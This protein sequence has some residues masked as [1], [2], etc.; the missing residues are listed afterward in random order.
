MQVTITKINRTTTDKKG[1]ALKTK[2]GRPYTRISLKTDQHEDKW[3]SGFENADTKSWKQGDSVEIEVTQ[4]GEYLN[5]KTPK[6]G[7]INDQA[8]K[9]IFD[10]TETILNKM[11]GMSFDIESLKNHLMPKKAKPVNDYTDDEEED[12]GIPF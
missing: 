8:L 1:D 10:N 9:D 3:L 6:K 12:S 5:F 4:N 7:E 2:D 11:V